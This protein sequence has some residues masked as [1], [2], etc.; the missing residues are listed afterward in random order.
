M[1][2]FRTD[3][4][5]IALYRGGK[6][7]T[8]GKAGPKKWEK[9]SGTETR[10]PYVWM[11]YVSWHSL[12]FAAGL[13]ITE[14]FT[15]LRSDRLIPTLGRVVN[16]MTLGKLSHAPAPYFNFKVLSRSQMPNITLCVRRMHFYYDLCDRAVLVCSEELPRHQTLFFW[17]SQ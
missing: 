15:L 10:L 1:R 14:F 2:C 11:K 13:P 16:V 5:R 3:F 4:G 7:K 9:R 12:S 6:I 8:F 17:L